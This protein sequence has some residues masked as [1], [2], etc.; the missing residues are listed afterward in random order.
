MAAIKE[1]FGLY[2]IIYSWI[3]KNYGYAELTKYWENTASEIYPGLARDFREKGPEYIKEYFETIFA[4][5]GGAA[6][7]TV[8]GAGV[9]IRVTD[10]P[11]KKW[12]EAFGYPSYA[13]KPWYFDRYR[14]VY[15]TVAEMAGLRCD[16]LDC[17]EDGRCTFRFSIKEGTRV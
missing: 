17:P 16:M 3:E 10:S 2:S 15:G 5:D 11:D 7:G 13:L 12:A 8:D 1:W 9:T 14:Y 6:A 4:A